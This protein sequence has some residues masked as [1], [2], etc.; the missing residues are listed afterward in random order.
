LLLISTLVA[1]AFCRA[2]LHLAAPELVVPD[3]YIVKLHDNVTADF[4]SI[5]MN[6]LMATN[7]VNVFA[8]WTIVN[9]YAATIT[10]KDALESLL[11]DSLVEYVEQN[12][13]IRLDYI[14]DK[15]VDFETGGMSF[16]TPLD[17]DTVS[18]QTGLVAGLWGLSRVW[19]R[20]RVSTTEYRFWTSAG[21]GVDAY[22]LDT[23]INAGHNEFLG[24]IVPGVSF[25][26]DN[27]F[28]GT[29]DGNGHGTHVASTVGGTTYGLAKRITLIAVKVL[30]SGGGGTVA[31]VVSG[32]DW[33]A[34][35]YNSRRR[36][37]VANMSLGGGASAI[38]DTAV[39]NA[40][41][42]GVTFVVAAGNDNAIACNTS[43]ARAVNAWTVGSIANTD[44]RST[45]SN[46]GTCTNIF[47]PGTSILG[48]WI[49]GV[50]ATNTI[51][52]TSMA[53]PHACGAAG[54]F[55]GHLEGNETPE[56][57]KAT[58][59]ARATLNAITNPGAGSPNRLIFT[60]TTD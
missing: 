37:S 14:Q 33:T 1:S 52:G 4:K 54:L 28:P 9:G 43:P 46:F 23:G 41:T 47:A 44:A 19:Q 26:T 31:G 27:N 45:F 60:S 56:V 6:K 3:S 5:H 51:S 39:N 8:T 32:V 38:L 42:A 21:T 35:S 49:P 34:S 13:I 17:E 10:S 16:S 22:I 29:A 50:S 24:R 55:L 18:S 7:S 36:P 48:A 30:S 12:Q 25:V 53:S 11:T 15:P 58:L 2:P 57:V 59:E 40:V 20:T